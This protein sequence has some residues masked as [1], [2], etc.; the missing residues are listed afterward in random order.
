MFTFEIDNEIELKLLER[1]DAKPLF[2]LVDKDRAYLREWL[3]WVDK[4][5]SEEGYH[6]IIDS[7]LK[8]FMD[9]DGFQAGI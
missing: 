6:P 2:A 1:D 4:S 8:Q 5:T 7:W 9:H 3:P